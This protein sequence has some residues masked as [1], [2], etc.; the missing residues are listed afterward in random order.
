MMRSRL[1][2]FVPEVNAEP[3]W[4]SASAAHLAGP[5]P[6]VGDPVVVVYEGG[7]SDYPVWQSVAVVESSA[8]ATGAYGGV[9]RA[10]VVAN[11]DPMQVNLLEVSV[12]GVS[13]IESVWA[14]RSS[15]LGYEAGV[16]E[17]GAAVWV[18]FEGGDVTRPVWVG[19]A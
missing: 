12:P 3:A 16:P 7:D 1:L 17:V 10:T 2:V 15:S 6:A 4:A 13:G 14:T 19:T 18:Q 11:I 9:Y 5:L 8:P